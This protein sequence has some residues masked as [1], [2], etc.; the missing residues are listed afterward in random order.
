M[1]EDIIDLENDLADLG[2]DYE[3]ELDVVLFYQKHLNKYNLF[4]RQI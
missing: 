2:I 1:K 3:T 4:K